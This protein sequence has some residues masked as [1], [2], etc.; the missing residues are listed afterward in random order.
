MTSIKLR[1]AP[2]RVDGS[3]LAGASLFQGELGGTKGL[4]RF[5]ALDGWR[6]VCATGVA[7]FHLN[8]YG[9]LYTSFIVRDAFLFVDFFFVLSGFVI[10]GAYWDRLNTPSAVGT[11]FIR[12]FG[13]LYPLHIF[14]LGLFFLFEALKYFVLMFGVSARFPAFAESFSID[15]LPGNILLLQAMGL[16]DHPTWNYPSWSISAEFYTNLLFGAVLLLARPASRAI[17]I[18]LL[19]SILVASAIWLICVSN[20]YIGVT[21]DYGYLRCIYGFLCGVLTQRMYGAMPKQLKNSGTWIEIATVTIT[22]LFV[23]FCA[24]GPISYATPLLFSFVVF[25][26]A[27]EGGRISKLLQTSAI[28]Q[29]GKLSYS[30]YMVHVFIILYVINRAVFFMEKHLHLNLTTDA[31]SIP[32]LDVGPEIRQL[33]TLGGQYQCDALTLLYIAIVI[34]FAKLT[35]DY[36][37]TPSRL[38]FNR[39]KLNRGKLDK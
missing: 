4:E 10:S 17:Q 15:T 12:R 30:I 31:N 24:T 3:E 7:L 32:A 29:L 14:V 23:C 2:R 16:Y 25:V 11:Y 19:L 39:I 26:F 22:L 21:F 28:Q 35:Y 5:R 8:V 34:G 20:R 38:Y 36:V 1:I 37:E 13:R 6:G 18:F 27:I 33:I 9:H